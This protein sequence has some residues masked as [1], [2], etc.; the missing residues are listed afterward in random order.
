MGC[1]GGGEDEEGEAGPV[2]G[3]GKGE[4]H[5]QQGTVPPPL[6]NTE[7]FNIYSFFRLL[8]IVRLGQQMD[9]KL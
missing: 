8:R 2:G 9:T 5:C 1:H 6:V 4:E 7:L 3:P